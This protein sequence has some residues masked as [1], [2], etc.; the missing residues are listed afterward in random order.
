MT[1]EIPIVGKSRWLTPWR[2]IAAR[3]RLFICVGVAFVVWLLEPQNWAPSTRALISWNVLTLLYAALVSHM[4]RGA[5]HEDIRE[6]A[7]MQD[8]GQTAILILAMVAATASV[9]AI[10]LQLAGVKDMHGTLKAFHI[11]LSS[12]TI[13]TSFMFIHLMFA[14]QYAHEYY[15]EW[16]ENPDAEATVRGGLTFPGTLNPQYADFLYVAFVIAVAS[17]TADVATSSRAM[18]M[19]V[20]IQGIVAFVFNTTVLALTINIAAGLLS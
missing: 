17:Q 11:G 15:A 9:V 8:E 10:I 3:P 2:A 18:R 20:M 16:V 6:N 7:R 13:I 5:T 19:L 4:M 12:L 1:E 14:L